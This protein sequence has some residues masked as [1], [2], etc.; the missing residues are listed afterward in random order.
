VIS[1]PI[2]VSPD[3]TIRQV[4]ELTR[5]NNISGMPVVLGTKVVG[6]VTHRDLRGLPGTGLVDSTI[7]QSDAKGARS[8][9]SAIS[10]VRRRC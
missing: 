3:M 8:S 5:A 10:C 2:T 7:T 9:F 4:I 6:I 1:D